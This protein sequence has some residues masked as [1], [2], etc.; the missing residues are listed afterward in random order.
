MTNI[1]GHK[2]KVVYGERRKKDGKICHITISQLKLH[3]SLWC[4]VIMMDSGNATLI[5]YGENKPN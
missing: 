1:L 4:L 3:G 2:I 5:Y